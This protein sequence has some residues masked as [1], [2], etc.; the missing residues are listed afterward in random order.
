[1]ESL[2]QLVIKTVAVMSMVDRIIDGFMFHEAK[3]RRP[4][5]SAKSSL[6]TLKVGLAT[7]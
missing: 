6:S 1:M 7:K 5:R 3:K 2:P 4:R